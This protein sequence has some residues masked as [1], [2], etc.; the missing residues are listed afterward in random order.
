MLNAATPTVTPV[1]SDSKEIPTWAASSIHSLHAM[2]VMTAVDGEISP[3]DSL[4]RADAACILSA[5]L[6]VRGAN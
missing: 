5:V 1:F 3:L 6:Q 2:G 4:S